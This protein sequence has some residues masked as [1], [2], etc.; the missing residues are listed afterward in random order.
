METWVVETIRSLGY[1]GIGLLMF[2]ENLFPPIPSELIMPLAGFTASKSGL[3]LIPAIAAGV[4]GTVLGAYPWYYIGKLVSEERLERW[5]DKYFKWIGISGED[6][7]KSKTWFQKHGA[8]AV[9][10]GRMVPGIRT[11]ISLPAGIEGMPII[12]FT[13]YTTLGTIIWTTALTLLGF[14]LGE[15]YELVEQYLAPVSKIVL[16]ILVLGFAAW[17]LKKNLDLRNKGN[18]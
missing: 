9:F 14:Q 10:L 18:G 3:G 15:K 5:A 11:L 2:L 7:G 4:I 12:P 8:K 13:I 17:L 1:F 16:G 6:V